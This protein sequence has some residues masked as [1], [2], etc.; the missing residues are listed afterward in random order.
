MLLALDEVKI[1]I[2]HTFRRNELQTRFQKIKL[3][4]AGI[5]R[6]DGSLGAKKNVI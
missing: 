5:N 3:S 2:R 6:T 4:N 1:I